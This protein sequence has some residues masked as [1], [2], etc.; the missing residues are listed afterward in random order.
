MA[1]SYPG[2][3]DN[4]ATNK[5][6]A[7]VTVN[8]HAA[9]HNDLA[10]AVNKIEAELGVDPAGGSATVAARL[11]TLATPDASVARVET[12]Q[13]TTSGTYTALATAGPAVTVTVTASGV[14]MVS[15]GALL[16]NN[17]ATSGAA[18]AFSLSGSNTLA[19]ADGRSIAVWRPEPDGFDRFGRT[20]VLTG[21]NAG[22]TTVTALYRTMNGNTASFS[23][24]EL[25]AVVGFV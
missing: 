20:F 18:M 16:A 14:L 7:T 17:N 19:A 13:T 5:T 15:I 2:G 4:F 25:S 8:D 12:A 3:L 23:E 21:L 22:S 24:R 11:D 1:S 10:D 9:H 6:N